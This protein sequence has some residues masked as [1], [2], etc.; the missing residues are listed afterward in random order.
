[1]NPARA[2]VLLSCS[3]K[4]PPF[5]GL[6][7]LS[8]LGA[9]ANSPV[10]L[11]DFPEPSPPKLRVSD[12]DYASRIRT[13]FSQQNAMALLGASIARVAPGEVDIDLPFHEK[14]TQQH[15][16]V[17]GGVIAAVMDSACGY[18]AST[19]MPADAG[20]LTVELKANFLA[21]AAGDVFRFRGK[22]KRAGRSVSFVEGEALAVK[23]G[24]SRVVATMQATMM[25]IQGRD[26]VKM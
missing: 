14:I 21:P 5:V 20:V 17:H 19:L 4:R 7:A 24:A 23:D 16:F 2:A 8:P 18:A 12:P 9:R 11:T 22:V 15:G 6:R 13:S 3:L 25:T 26:D 10:S 1:M